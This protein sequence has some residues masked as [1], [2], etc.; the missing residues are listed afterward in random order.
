M[1]VPGRPQLRIGI[2]GVGRAGSA[3]GGALQRAGH[4]V[5]A[6]HA[7]SEASRAKADALFPAAVTTD[8]PGV[9]A[10]ADLVLLTVPDD[11][12]PG[13]VTGI[14]ATSAAR[15]SQIV[16]HCS[17]RYGLAVLAPLTAAGVIPLA[18]HPAMTLTGTTVDVQ[19]L[20][21]APFAITAPES[22]RPVAE[23][24]VVEMGGEPVWVPEEARPSYHAALTHAANHLV[25]LI[26]DAMDLLAGAGVDD[27]A[28]L[29][30]PLVT[31]ALDNVLRSGDAALT[32]PVSRGDAG[33]VAA[34]LDVLLDEPGLRRAYLAMA[35]RT[36]DRAL[37]SGRLS[38]AQGATLLA[39]LASNEQDT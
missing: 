35:R 22:M 4:L 19:R 33:T 38:A 9:F 12:L 14:E 24:L 37:A 11:V 27:S 39:L 7:I 2:V 6:V 8:V 23:A 21:G 31:A 29:L 5:V 36:A 20:T 15:P 18:L 25:T 3:V 28:R 30:A 16:V 26:A 32:G 13:L 1:M 17:G 10:A 34:H